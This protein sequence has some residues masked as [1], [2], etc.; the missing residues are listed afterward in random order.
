MMGNR[1]FLG[2]P[3]VSESLKSLEN[4][5]QYTNRTS[6]LAYWIGQAFDQSPQMIDFFFQQVLGGWWKYQKALFPVGGENVDYTLGV[7]GQ[8][9]KDNQYS[10][11]LVNNLY[12]GLDKA[13]KHKNSNPGDTGA[14]IAYKWFNNMTTFYSRYYKLAK[15]ETETNVTR[16]VRQTVLNMISEFEKNIDHDYKTSEQQAVED[17]CLNSGNTESLPGVMQ[18][19]IKD[20]S[21]ANHNLTASQY[22]EYQTEYLSDYWDYVEAALERSTDKSNKTIRCG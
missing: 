6:K 21:G 7:Q 14:A 20:D 2:K 22:V 17:I 10:T 16:G 13:D 1:D 18:S 15:N 11:D 5:D 4:K 19:T 9:V 8:Y 3:I 12:D